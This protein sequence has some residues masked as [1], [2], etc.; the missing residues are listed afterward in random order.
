[1]YRVGF[2]FYIILYYRNILFHVYFSRLPHMIT[3]KMY[4][5]AAHSIQFNWRISWKRN[6]IYAAHVLSLVWKYRGEPKSKKPR[7]PNIWIKSKIVAYSA[8]IQREIVCFI[9]FKCR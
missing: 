1:M 5:I 9:Y 4:F 7:M 2:T 8:G 3:S 6:G